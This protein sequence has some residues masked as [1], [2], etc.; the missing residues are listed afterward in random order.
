VLENLSTSDLIFINNAESKIQNLLTELHNKHS[1]SKIDIVSAFFGYKGFVKDFI[2]KCISNKIKTRIIVGSSPYHIPPPEAIQLH[3]AYKKSDGLITLNR[4]AESSSNPQLHSKFYLFYEKDKEEPS[5]FLFGS[6]NM[7]PAG[8]S[9]TYES[10]L[11]GTNSSILKILKEEFEKIPKTDFDPSIYVKESKI[12]FENDQFESKLTPFNYQKKIID[13][14]SS[15]FE[16]YD[17]GN[18][19]LPCGTGKTLIS[20]WVKEKIKAQKVLVFLPSLSLLNQTLQVWN[21]EKNDDYNTLCVCSD[22]S[23]GLSDDETE[24]NLTILENK[25]KRTQITVTPSE[26]KK[27][28]NDNEKFVIFSTYHSS[29]KILEAI[30]EQKFDC[31]VYDESH[32]IAQARDMAQSEEFM[33]QSHHIEAKKKLFMTATPK[34]LNPEL[35]GN[36]KLRI[37]SMDDSSIF[38]PTFYNMSFREAIEDPEIP[39]VDYK[40]LLIDQ[41]DQFQKLGSEA[42][43]L[44]ISQT[45][46]LDV[47]AAKK[48]Q[49]DKQIDIRKIISYHSKIQKAQLFIDRSTNFEKIKNQ[50]LEDEVLYSD[51]INGTMSV[52]TRLNILDTFATS[53]IGL[54]TNV[55]CLTEGIDVPQI[56]AVFFSDPKTSIIDIIQ[57]IGRTLRRDPKNPDKIA[58]VIVPIYNGE[59]GYASLINILNALKHVDE[60]LHALINKI[61]DAN[62]KN[63]S[64]KE[65]LDALTDEYLEFLPANLTTDKIKKIQDS[66]KIEISNS[67]TITER[68]L[69]QYTSDQ[70]GFWKRC[71]A[72]D[73]SETSSPGQF[74]IPLEFVNMFPTLQEEEVDKGAQFAAVFNIQFIDE[75]GNT[76]DVDDVRILKYVPASDHPRQNVDGRFTFKNS[77]FWVR[78]GISEGD[79]LVFEKTGNTSRP[80]RVE[81]IKN[82]SSKMNEHPFS[83]RQN[84]GYLI[85][86]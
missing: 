18:M 12:R 81:L 26:I 1:I 4:F 35:L 23:V 20:L 38:G 19:I 73:V 41:T 80:L 43:E 44:D 7:T 70:N 57:A 28:V 62:R 74:I 2:Q 72:S 29:V 37:Y 84:Y 45:A 58:Y 71:S 49:S 76:E 33:T 16:K 53:D 15:E 8:F 55:R 27:F 63:E 34:I 75:N 85:S 60:P 30:G 21:S 47:Y 50:I 14:I 25:V 77:S 52:S 82:N 22:Q 17:K 66:L 36:E 79:I 42:N 13:I 24:S 9:T 65:H 40:I 69:P 6:S 51:H 48:T 86:E 78:M 10:N 68:S 39:I 59:G 5:F 11:F 54:V 3:E 56:D 67:L 31:I 61:N 83:S 46:L 32:N 64:V